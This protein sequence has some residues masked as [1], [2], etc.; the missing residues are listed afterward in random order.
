MGSTKVPAFF[1][2]IYTQTLDLLFPPRCVTCGR[3]GSVWCQDCSSQA[4]LIKEP[5]CRRCGTPGADQKDC[6]HCKTWHF[7]FDEA[8][9]WGK[10]SGRLREA[11]LSIKHRYNAQLG[12][13]L[14]KHVANVFFAQEWKVDFVVPIPLAPHRLAERGYNQAEVLAKPFASISRLNFADNILYR[15]HET[16]KQFELDARERWNNLLGAFRVDGHDLAGA[17]ILLIDDIMTTGATLNAAAVTLKA[18]GCS[19]VFALTLAKT[20]FNEE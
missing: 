14:A 10:Y 2:T 13:E 11:I 12:R 1:Q 20:L 7:N 16:V 15:S 8:R 4:D 5:Y 9:A 17:S 3:L 6:I 19:K 18:A